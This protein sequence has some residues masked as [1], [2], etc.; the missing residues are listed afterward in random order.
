MA[1]KNKEIEKPWAVYPTGI[2]KVVRKDPHGKIWITSFENSS[3]EWAPKEIQT[4]E[5]SADA[6][7]Y[8]SVH[9]PYNPPYTFNQLAHLFLDQFPSEAK[10]I[11]SLLAQSLPKCT[12]NQSEQKDEGPFGP[13]PFKRDD[14]FVHP[15]KKY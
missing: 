5:K 9:Q 6:I 15:N 11:E 12:Q 1:E 3:P 7:K 13:N 4:F 2:G 14:G 8:F 10:N